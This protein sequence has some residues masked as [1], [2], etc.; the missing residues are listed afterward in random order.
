MI[1]TIITFCTDRRIDQLFSQ[2]YAQ[3]EV[4]NCNLLSELL[5][6]RSCSNFFN[7]RLF[8]FSIVYNFFN[9]LADR[10]TDLG[11]FGLFQPYFAKNVPNVSISGKSGCVTFFALSCPN[12]VQKIIQIGQTVV[13][14]LNFEESCNLIGQEAFIAP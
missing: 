8:N 14:I 3:P 12:S 13:E 11:H 10:L 7:L 5:N 1:G 9:F 4:E 2:A 6:F